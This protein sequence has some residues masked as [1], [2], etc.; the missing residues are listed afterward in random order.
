[1]AQLN[2]RTQ[3]KLIDFLLLFLLI[4]AVIIG[5]ICFRMYFFQ[6]DKTSENEFVVTKATLS[7]FTYTNNNLQYNIAFNIKGPFHTYGNN[8][9]ALAM[10]HNVSFAST[11]LPIPSIDELS[12]TFNGQQGMSFGG[13]Q[14]SELNRDKSI[15]IYHITM[16][17]CFMANTASSNTNGKKP[18]FYCDM[19]VPLNSNNGTSSSAIFPATLCDLHYGDEGCSLH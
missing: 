5:I 16:K 8:V 9:E 10:Y 4:I 2:H 14:T 18:I 19:H 13:D 1:M 15:N 11:K 3:T 7:Q 12:I 6:P 17:V